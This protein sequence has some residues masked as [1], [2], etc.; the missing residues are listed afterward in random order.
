MTVSKAVRMEEDRQAPDA[1][2]RENL[3]NK[4]KNP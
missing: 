4:I 3:G 1:V 2:K